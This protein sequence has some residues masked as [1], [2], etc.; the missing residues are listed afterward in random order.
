M[1]LNIATFNAGSSSLSMKLFA[2]DL[3]LHISEVFSAKAHRVAVRGVEEGHI[4]YTIPGGAGRISAALPSHT[5]AA[6]TLIELVRDRGFTID[7]I[8]HRFVHGGFHFDRS[9]WLSPTELKRL[10]ACR[11]LAPIHNPN[12]LAVIRVA[13]REMPSVPQYVA[14]DTAFH[15]DLPAEARTYALPYPWFLNP[16]MRKIGFH[17]LSYQDVTTKTARFLS[18][19]PEEMT[20]VACHLGTRG[21]SVAAIRNGRSVDT[22]MGATPTAG[23]V[24]STRSGDVDPMIPLQL[25][26][27]LSGGVEQVRQLLNR[28]SGLFGL[29]GISS[30]IRDLLAIARSTQP[31]SGFSDRSHVRAALAVRVYVHR[32][33]SAI[34][35]MWAVAGPVDALV[36]TDD[37]G[38]TC[39]QVREEVC[40]RLR[41]LGLRLDPAANRARQVQDVV[42]LH[43]REST[44][45]ILAVRNDE[46]RVIAREGLFLTDPP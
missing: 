40:E 15:H 23:L 6:D 24:M 38:L 8:G 39:P 16:T 29:S 42:P 10:D 37:I 17:G 5:I 28:N 9:A 27:H 34:G 12:S 25:A 36:F 41:H 20:L 1:N 19:T 45:P 7:R 26:D 3:S 13:Q 43:A 11:P 4:S 21:S 32:L 18:L 2:I 31:G 46:D 35:A 44:I 30:D 33:I 22:S 14:F